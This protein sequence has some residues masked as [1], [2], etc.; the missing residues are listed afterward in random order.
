MFIGKALNALGFTQGRF[1]MCALHGES[2]AASS[3]YKARAAVTL[4]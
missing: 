3:L 2:K 4:L 1:I